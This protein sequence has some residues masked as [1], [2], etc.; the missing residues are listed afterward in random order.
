MRGGAVEGQDW[1]A[2]AGRMDWWPEELPSSY[3]VTTCTSG[4]A[5]LGPAGAGALCTPSPFMT[6]GELRCQNSMGRGWGQPALDGRPPGNHQGWG[7]RRSP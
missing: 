1:W 6:P 3:P 4:L 7:S 5:G 2:L